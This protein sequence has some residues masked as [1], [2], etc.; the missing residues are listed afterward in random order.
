MPHTARS[1]VRYRSLLLTLTARD[2]KARYRGSMLGYFWSL[3]NPLLLL[4]VYSFVFGYIFQPARAFGTDPYAIFLVTG[5]FPWVWVSG[6][7]LEGVAS[8]TTN[9]G[10]IRKAIFPA[11]VLPTV[12]V[13]ANGVHFL[14]ALPILAVALGVGRALGD[15]VGGWSALLLPLV[16]VL[17]VP[18][19]A[20]LALGLAALNVHF[21]DV[22]DLLA[23]LLT[24]AFFLTPIL[25]PL[26]AVEA[27]APAALT[28]LIRLNPF[29]PFTLGYQQLLF[30]G[31]VPGL[32][33]WLQM[34][35]MAALA[36]VVGSRLFER[37]RET[38]VEAV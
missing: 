23:N 3:V 25:Y 11:E 4:G 22:R 17:Q 10:L 37:L 5:V 26:D 24:L 38:L 32:L 13:L 35:A 36:W 7:L 14:L 29:T 16:I 19:L 30:A 20:G 8:L 33:L 21:K 34:A 31:E 12:A 9:A 28:L 6:S 15:P 27:R 1:I 2:L 18:L